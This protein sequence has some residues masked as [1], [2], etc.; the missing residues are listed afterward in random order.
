MGKKNADADGLSRLQEE[1]DQHDVA[2]P[3]VLKAISFA[4]QVVSG[5]CRL[6]ESL[7]LSD[8]ALGAGS[9]LEVPEQ[10][11]QTSALSDR[12][13]RKAQWQD[14]ALRYIIKCLQTGASKPVLKILAS[15]TYN[16]TSQGLGQILSVRHHSLQKGHCRQSGISAA[17][18]SSFR[19]EIFKAL[20]SD[21]GHQGRDRTVSLIKQRFWPGID[22]FV[23]ANVG[24]CDCCIRRKTK[25]DKSAEPANIVLTSPWNRMSV[26][27]LLGKVQRRL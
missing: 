3:G 20:H 21:L 13:W 14:P 1:E 17:S 24:Q 26:L 5:K 11:L 4:A 7:A 6:V 22:S 27:S 25:T 15:S 19:H 16:K 9:P 2:F 12:D 10:L 23:K 8:T 18:S